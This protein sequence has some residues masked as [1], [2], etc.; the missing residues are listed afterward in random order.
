LEAA[1]ININPIKIIC[2]FKITNHKSMQLFI[3]V[4]LLTWKEA[5]KWFYTSGRVGMMRRPIFLI[6]QKEINIK[7]L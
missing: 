4:N 7:K 6:S 1:A 3:H 5:I 2:L